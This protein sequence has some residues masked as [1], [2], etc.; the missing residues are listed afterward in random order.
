MHLHRRHRQA[1]GGVEIAAIPTDV[2]AAGLRPARIVRALA[3]TGIAIHAASFFAA[4]ILLYVTDGAL[5]AAQAL[6]AF[7]AFALLVMARVT[8]VLRRDADRSAWI[9]PI[10]RVMP[11]AVGSGLGL[12]MVYYGAPDSP[13][14]PLAASAAWETG[15]RSPAALGQFVA[16]FT[17]AYVGAGV[18]F[19]F[20]PGLTRP[21]IIM[22]V[23]KSLGLVW[24][25]GFI[26]LGVERATHRRGAG[27][28]ALERPFASRQQTR[29]RI[30]HALRH[31]PL[32]VDSLIAGAHL[33]LEVRETEML[34]FLVMGLTNQEVADALSISEAT[35][36]YRLT[37]LYRRLGVR[38][39]AEAIALA[40]SMGMERMPDVETGSDLEP[41]A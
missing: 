6:I 24:L 12:T 27:L 13:L 8:A 21:E 23:T 2:L 34:G 4:L 20:Q 39:R 31:E 32:P 11:A 10:V 17:L 14:L 41:S 25:G 5:P 1:A 18:L 15:R 40:R 26:G 9:D 33:G 38:R 16:L 7:A 36:K 28:A 29:A 35:V 3:D 37:R 30:A 22:E 19:R